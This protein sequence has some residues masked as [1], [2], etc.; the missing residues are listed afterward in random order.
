AAASRRSS[1]RYSPT[2]L[3]ARRLG[4][5]FREAPGAVAHRLPGDAASHSAEPAVWRNPDRLQQHRDAALD[6]MRPIEREGAFG[7][8]PA[9]PPALIRALIFIGRVIGIG[10]LVVFRFG[11]APDRDLEPCQPPEPL[12]SKTAFEVLIEQAVMP[13]FVRCDMAA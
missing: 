8:G 3:L 12:A 6:M 11:D 5:R 9:V 10:E 2:T 1:R 4:C 13:E 7:I